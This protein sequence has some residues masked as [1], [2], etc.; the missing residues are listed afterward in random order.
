MAIS[1][2]YGILFG[3]I[4]ILL[5]LPIQ[6]VLFNRFQYR[7]KRFFGNK[8]VTP[9]GVEAAVINHQIDQRLE[10]ALEEEEKQKKQ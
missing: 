9:E 1:V 8:D 2:A 6:I 3:S 10:K 5:T 4:F 7:M